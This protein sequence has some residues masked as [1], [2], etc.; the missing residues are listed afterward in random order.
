MNVTDFLKSAR[1]KE[2]FRTLGRGAQLDEVEEIENQLRITLPNS[3][4]ELV[5]NVG[6]VRWFGNEV[7]GVSGNE[8]NE[9]VARTHLQIELHKK[10]AN[11]LPPMPEKGNIIAEIF[12][13]GFCFLYSMESERAGQI[14]AHTPD[15]Q[16]REVQYWDSLEDYFDYLIHG[17]KN[18]HS[19]EQ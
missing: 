8:Q 14:S 4:R 15:E 1:P 5:E 2:F 12:G 11:Q 18:W 6:F 16:Y 10:F 19:V 3:Y 17:V 9:T 13:G 7:F